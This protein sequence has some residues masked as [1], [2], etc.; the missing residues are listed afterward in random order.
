MALKAL[1]GTLHHEHAL[2]EGGL[3]N[4]TVPFP[5]ARP[6]YDQSSMPRA[7]SKLE[8]CAFSSETASASTRRTRATSGAGLALEAAA[9][10]SNLWRATTERGLSPAKYP[11]N[12]L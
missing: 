10:T 1:A 8:R 12:R 6:D 9:G 7:H 2:K 11:L 4:S 5:M 3:L